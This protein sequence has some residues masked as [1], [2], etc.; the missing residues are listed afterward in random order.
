MAEE[1]S[2]AQGDRKEL[3]ARP[4]RARYDKVH[5]TLELKWRRRELKCD[6]MMREVVDT[7][8]DVFAASPYSWCGF[9]V[10][11]PDAKHL[12]LGPH[13]EEPLPSPIDLQG[14][15]GRVFQFAKPEIVSGG[16]ASSQILLPVFD[17]EAKVWAV[18]EVRSSRSAAFDGMDQRWLEK[19]LK[20]FRDVR[21][22]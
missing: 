7:L 2:Q 6:R 17:R 11:S 14:A 12:T 18:F 21:R 19:I 10:L 9:Y 4:S 5:A 22:Q 8:W 13:R 1:S 20:P 16:P 3:S 15:H